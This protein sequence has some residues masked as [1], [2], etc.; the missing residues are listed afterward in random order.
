M[1]PRRY[2]RADEERQNWRRYGCRS[3]YH[4][5]KTGRLWSAPPT[6]RSCRN[7]SCR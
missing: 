3:A 1:L 5:P 2:S 4:L 7:D 6:P